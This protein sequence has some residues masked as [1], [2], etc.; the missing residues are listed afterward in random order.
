MEVIEGTLIEP[1]NP[2]ALANSQDVLP[3]DKREY[4]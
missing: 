4:E 3:E 1:Q 2:E